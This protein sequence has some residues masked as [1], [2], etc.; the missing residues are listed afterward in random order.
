MQP[1]LFIQWQERNETGIAII[2]EQ[3]KGIVSIINTFFYLMGHGMNSR[4]LYSCISDTMRNY[5]RIHFL[6]EEGLLE[7]AG[8]GK[9]EAHRKLHRH[10]ILEI[11]R[12]EYQAAKFDDAQPLLDFLKKWWITHIN[13]EDMQ[14]VDHLRRCLPPFWPRHS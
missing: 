14:F 12:I 1:P 6:A 4:I 2:D 13:E 9:I 3:H 10:L 8:Y 5:S 7:A 11:D